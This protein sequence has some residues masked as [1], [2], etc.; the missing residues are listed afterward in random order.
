MLSSNL[1]DIDIQFVS[2]NVAC[3]CFLL[4]TL[5]SAS[6]TLPVCEFSE[7]MGILQVHDT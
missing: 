1:I 4:Q 7:A 6:S 2:W 3:I 5:C